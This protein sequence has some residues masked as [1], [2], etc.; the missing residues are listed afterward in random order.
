[1]K[2]LF[3]ILL[4]PLIAAAQLAPSSAPNMAALRTL[5]PRN[6]PI[7]VEGYYSPRDGGG[8]WYTATNTISGTNIYG[9]R[10]VALGGTQSWELQDKEPNV[11]QFGAFA[12]GATDTSLQQQ[13][14]IDFANSRGLGVVK[15]P[16]NI[17][18]YVGQGIYTRNLTL[19]GPSKTSWYAGALL[20]HVKGATNHHVII[21]IESPGSPGVA[22]FYAP[23]S[24]ASAGLENLTLIGHSEANLRNPRVITAVTSRSEFTVAVGDLPTAPPAPASWPYYGWCFFYN[25]NGTS[26]ANGKYMGAGLVTNINY[27]TGVVQ[28]DV[29]TALY[30]TPTWSSELL[31]VGW[32]VCFS[33]TLTETA[34]YGSFTSPDMASAG[35]C[36][37]FITCTNAAA[38]SSLVNIV[39]VNVH[40][41][42]AGI[43][44]GATLSTRIINSFNKFN[45]WAS[46]SEFQPGVARDGTIEDMF[47]FM[48]Y[49]PNYS[50]NEG[51]NDD[52]TVYDNP[53]FRFGV[54][55][56]YGGMASGTMNKMAVNFG[57]N[58]WYAG[59]MT[60]FRVGDVLLE[61]IPGKS[62]WL[63]GSRFGD[64]QSHI[65][66]DSLVFRTFQTNQTT[67]GGFPTLTG[68]TNFVPL[69]YKNTQLGTAKLDID[70]VTFDWLSSQNTQWPHAINLASSGSQISI[71]A[72]IRTN[73]IS[74]AFLQP[75]SA[76]PTLLG[77][78]DV[79][80]ITGFSVQCNTFGVFGV[81]YLQ[82]SGASSILRMTR[83]DVSG[84]E[85]SFNL[86]SSIGN[87]T[88]AGLVGYS[89]ESSGGW[90]MKDTDATRSTFIRS[91]ANGS[92]TQY[93]SL[94]EP[95]FNGTDNLI[96]WGGGSSG[97]YVA[98]LQDFVVGGTTTTTTGTKVMRLSPAGIRIST[99]GI[100]GS[101]SADAPVR[102]DSTTGG[103]LPPRMTK[104]QRDAISSPT[105]GL[106]LYQSDGTAG[107]KIRI[108]GVWYTVNV[109]ADP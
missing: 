7:F 51:G 41:Y 76:T 99:T 39:D 85:A 26:S 94:V 64:N 87:W 34:S 61:G 84:L 86:G 82:N 57:V 15:Y 23:S 73:G 105:D 65:H 72:I 37:V 32:K 3:Y 22:R 33:P 74:G 71:K 50:A 42:H 21:N 92:T 97:A 6:V 103:I 28:M 25:T 68:Y 46:Y 100:A 49:Q 35:Y 60:G 56:Q 90:Y 18:S 98:T 10:I 45:N 93:V 11:L 63:D 20:E 19:K 88:G 31:P 27:T 91:L 54:F 80:G 53:A 77:R 70:M 4:L 102:V 79:N 43:R 67:P 48:K 44:V 78:F 36:G 8:G 96:Q 107:L 29:E 47:H 75:G 83:P 62:L 59:S 16:G 95:L 24:P 12:D 81:S 38:A 9:G 1:M 104:A 101:T 69:Y 13:A 108:G 106:F 17:N 14:A 55:G 109:T 2:R 89:I 66:I 30:A 52:N 5:T 58:G 40:G